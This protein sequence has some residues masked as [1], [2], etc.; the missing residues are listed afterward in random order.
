VRDNMSEVK[1]LIENI[2]SRRVDSAYNAYEF[3]KEAGN[4]WAM[5]YWADVYSRLIQNDR[6]LGK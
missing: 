6:S 4:K 3:A 2:W 1:Q 5:N